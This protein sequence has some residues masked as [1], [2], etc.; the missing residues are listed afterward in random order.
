[1]PSNFFNVLEVVGSN[2]AINMIHAIVQLPKW[3]P[4]YNNAMR[5]HRTAFGTT[6]RRRQCNETNELDYNIT[7]GYI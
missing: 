7:E 6:V 2:D 5:R 1:M 3:V 4:P